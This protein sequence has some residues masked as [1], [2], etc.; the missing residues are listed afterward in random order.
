MTRSMTVEEALEGFVAVV[1]QIPKADL[2]AVHL[3]LA[4]TDAIAAAVRG[5]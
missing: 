1:G 3:S 5:H 4:G 2:D